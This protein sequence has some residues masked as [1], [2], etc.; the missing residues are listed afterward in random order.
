MS[1]RIP[2]L[3][4]LSACLLTFACDAGDG[5][6]DEAVTHEGQGDEVT[7]DPAFEI[8]LT[9]PDGKEIPFSAR[10]FAVYQAKPP[11]NAEEKERPQTFELRG[12]GFVLAGRMPEALKLAPQKKYATL[13]GQTLEV[14]SH[15][16]DPT[17]PSMTKLTTP[18]DGR[19]YVARGGT[20]TVEKAFF[21]RGQ[22]AGVGGSFNVELQEIKLGNP[23]DPA[24]KEDK[25]VGDPFKATGVFTARAESYPYEQL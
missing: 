5:G 20:L 11:R 22:Y 7:S 24:N 23:D 15:G 17:A 3:L 14:R 6:T 16:G 9:L 8:K 13:A 10:S 4:L 1:H 19:V 25:P 12:E 18:G 2:F 21:R